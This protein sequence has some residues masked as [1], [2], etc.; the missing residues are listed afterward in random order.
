MVVDGKLSYKFDVCP[1]CEGSGLTKC[2][3]CTHGRISHLESKST[4][5]VNNTIVQKV[6]VYKT[7]PFCHGSGRLGKCNHVYPGDWEPFGRHKLPDGAYYHLTAS[8]GARRV[9]VLLNDVRLRIYVGTRVL[10]MH[11]KSGKLVTEMK[12]LTSESTA[13]LM[14]SPW[15]GRGSLTPA[16]AF[17]RRC[18]TDTRDDG[19]WIALLTVRI[20]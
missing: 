5:L 7:C 17:C 8:N 4:K 20:Q 9:Y 16:L 13:S 12:D 10:T 11:R 6:R 18:A 2:P 19:C 14:S 1:S 3:H 15:V